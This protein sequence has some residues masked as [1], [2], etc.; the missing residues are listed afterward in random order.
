MVGI[1]S[2][3]QYLDIHKKAQGDINQEIVDNIDEQ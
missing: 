1:Q 2:C 3:I